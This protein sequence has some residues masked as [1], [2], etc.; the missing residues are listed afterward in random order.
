MELAVI[1][2]GEVFRV[3]D[4]VRVKSFCSEDLLRYKILDFYTSIY[5]EFLINFSGNRYSAPEE[6]EFMEHEE[7]EE[8]E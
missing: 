7:S 4:K 5:G 2:Q 8:N 6:I 1:F 3:G